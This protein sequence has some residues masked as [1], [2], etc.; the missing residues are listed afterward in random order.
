MIEPALIG[1]AAAGGIGSM[2]VAMHYASE[3]KKA[4][5][6]SPLRSHF[7]EGTFKL[8][9]APFLSLSMGRHIITG[10]RNGQPMEL[11]IEGPKDGTKHDHDRGYV[12]RIALPLTLPYAFLF[13]A[14]REDWLTKVGKAL[15][16]LQDLQIGQADLDALL[17]FS[18]SEPLHLASLAGRP[19]FLAALRLLAAQPDFTGLEAVEGKL[20]VWRKTVRLPELVRAD[21]VKPALD[22]AAALAAAIF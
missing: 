17:R 22:A 7:E 19:A 8:G 15:H 12:M 1:L 14:G 11:W 18:S 3:R 6:L 2:I 5:A 16:L 10:R 9:S 13:R 4:D 21:T 20:L